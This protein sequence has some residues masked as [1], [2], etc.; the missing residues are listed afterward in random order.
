MELIF[1]HCG[2][3][4]LCPEG[5][6]SQIHCPH[7]RVGDSGIFPDL[8]KSVQILKREWGAERNKKL[9]HLF[10]ST[11]TASFVPEFAV[12]DLPFWQ[13]CSLGF[14][15]CSEEAALGQNT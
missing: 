14:C 12:E 2:E 15:A 1:N 3:F 5:P 4:R 11:K 10:I 8:F 13:N 7:L 6:A 9:P